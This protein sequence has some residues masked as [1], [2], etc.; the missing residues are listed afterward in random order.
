MLAELNA[1]KEAWQAERDSMHQLELHSLE[2]ELEMQRDSHSTAVCNLEQKYADDLAAVKKS[3][4]QDR[5]SALTELEQQR[6]SNISE[7][8]ASLEQRLAT[9]EMEL[10]DEL[11]SAVSD[12]ARLR[13]EVSDLTLSKSKSVSDY[14][15]HIAALKQKLDL[16]SQQ[17]AQELSEA[18]SKHQR[19]IDDLKASLE[20]LQVSND[21]VQEELADRHSHEVE[22]FGM[23]QQIKLNLLSTTVYGEVTKLVDRVGLLRGEVADML[24]RSEVDLK[25]DVTVIER[26]M[27]RLQQIHSL[28]MSQAS[29]KYRE[30]IAYC[31]DQLHS[32]QQEHAQSMLQAAADHQEEM[33]RL[34]QQIEE[35]LTT[36]HRSVV[37]D[38]TERHMTEVNHL[39][40]EIGRLR[41]KC[42]M[43]SLEV[44]DY[45]SELKQHENDIALLKESHGAHLQAMN[46]RHMQELSEIQEWKDRE[47]TQSVNSLETKHA[48]EMSEAEESHR[49]RVNKLMEQVEQLHRDYKQNVT[50]IHEEKKGEISSLEETVITLQKQNENVSL[51]LEFKNEEVMHLQD[52]LNVLGQEHSQMLQEIE[53]GSHELLEWKQ[54]ADKLKADY[55]AL[56]EKTGEETDSLH[57][58][59][60]IVQSENDR[61]VKEHASKHE[62]EVTRFQTQ[63]DSVMKATEEEVSQ[64]KDSMYSLEEHLSEAASSHLLEIEQLKQ[65]HGEEKVA[66]EGS[67]SLLQ[68]KVRKLKA[69]LAE[70]ESSAVD[71]NLLKEA[72]MLLRSETEHLRELSEGQSS[73]LQEEASEHLK[74]Q[75]AKEEVDEK[76]SVVERQLQEIIYEKEQLEKRCRELEA[77]AVDLQSISTEI[78]KLFLQRDQ[79]KQMVN[80][81]PVSSQPQETMEDKPVIRRVPVSYTHLTL[82]TKR[83]V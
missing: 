28:S 13:A 24:R 10:S 35:S 54:L 61:M 33:S 38:L 30:E 43:L 69:A 77:Q 19:A 62:E 14:E 31:K 34:R 5:K 39:Q 48:N 50:D 8:K 59:L 41:E 67:V 9:R 71:V 65:Q 73:K 49:A 44:A 16:Q 83:I 66:L 37:S 4:E 6:M 26:E 2:M 47:L 82:P 1:E 12:A 7:V 63:I 25:N 45:Q 42:D 20:F 27:Q 74:L 17:H 79:S 40:T 18:E 11:H 15:L 76:L 57:T 21:K 36:Q 52:Q 53:H 64:L 72:N 75:T 55:S 32:V 68:D 60:E 58:Q 22:M 81:Q 23:A 56:V 70:K 29:S 51:Q 3:L 78:E 80:S 46:E